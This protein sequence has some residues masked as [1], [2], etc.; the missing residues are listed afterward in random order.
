MIF[1][2]YFFYQ[3]YY[4]PHFYKN[5]YFKSLKYQSAMNMKSLEDHLNRT[6]LIS[7]QLTPKEESWL[8]ELMEEC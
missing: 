7:L 3:Y 6:I 1:L 8:L 5:Y 2:Y 4:Y